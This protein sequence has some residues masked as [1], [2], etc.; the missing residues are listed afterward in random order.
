MNAGKLSEN[1]S[2]RMSQPGTP[3]PLL[4]RFPQHVSQK[5]DQNVCLNTVLFMMPDRPDAQVGFLN[6]KSGLGFRELDVGF[7]KLLVSPV[8]NVAP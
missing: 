5:A 7:P 3:L 2:G 4:K 6:P 1:G 8:V